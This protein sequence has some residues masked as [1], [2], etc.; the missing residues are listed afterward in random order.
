MT[1]RKKF[2]RAVRARM[3]K[4]GESYAAARAVLNEAPKGT[5]VEIPKIPIPDSITMATLQRFLEP[6]PEVPPKLR[7]ACARLAASIEADAVFAWSPLGAELFR[8]G[9]EG[10]FQKAKDLVRG[11][12]DLML[13][14]DHIGPFAPHQYGRAQQLICLRRI[15]YAVTL[16]VVFPRA[17]GS[18]ELVR[19]RVGHA[20]LA[21]ER[22]F[23]AAGRTI[24]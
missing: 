22:A 10:L 4:T 9:D 23:A 5:L 24:E 7:R 17:P 19:L 12:Y 13:A 1:T 11:S 2:K 20:A 14:I 18:I 15:G 21:I 3:E 8:V 16:A 6:P